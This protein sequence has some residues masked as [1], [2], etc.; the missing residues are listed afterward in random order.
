[1]RTPLVILG[2]GLDDGRKSPFWVAVAEVIDSSPRPN[3][4][5]LMEGELQARGRSG[6]QMSIGAEAERGARERLEN[7]PRHFRN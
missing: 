3:V 4:L 5:V 7:F 6:L 2:E 1:M